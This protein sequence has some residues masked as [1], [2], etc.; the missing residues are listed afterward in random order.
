MT[1]IF[2]AVPWWLGVM[3][4]DSPVAASRGS[5]SIARRFSASVSFRS[6]NCHSAR[7]LPA[8]SNPTATGTASA[9]TATAAAL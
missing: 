4:Y 1:S 9:S 7:A 5:A 6:K 3:K 8:R 2:A